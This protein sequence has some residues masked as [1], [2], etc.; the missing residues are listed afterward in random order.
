V[1]PAP[2]TKNNAPSRGVV[3]LDMEDRMSQHFVGFFL[4]GLVSLPGPVVGQDELDEPLASRGDV[5]VTHREFDARISVIPEADRVPFIRDGKRLERLLSDLLLHK[6]LAAEA[7]AAGFDQDPMVRTR[8]ELSSRVELARAWL[9][10]YVN[11]HEEAD[12]MALARE[13]YLVDPTKFRSQ[14]TVDVSHILISSEERSLEEAEALAKD[15]RAR[16]EEDPE[17]WDSLVMS[18]SE[19]PSVTSNGG[20]FSA[21]KRGDMVKP[22]ENAAFAMMEGQISAPVRT[23]YGYH[24]IRLDAQNEPEQL[25]FDQVKN[26]LA[27]QQRAAHKERIRVDYLNGFGQVET[28]MTEEGLLKMISRYRAEPDDGTEA[29]DNSE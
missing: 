13:Q 18:Y 14:P 10:H 25:A 7:K 9:E 4:A 24:I 27:E 22:F 12:Y 6:Q 1:V 29:R 26:R 5:V 2:E 8:M 23:N 19:D 3:F 20:S 11:Q 16:L 21:V 28:D 15:L 17:S